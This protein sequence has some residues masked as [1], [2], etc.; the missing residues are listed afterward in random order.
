MKKLLVPALVLAAIGFASCSDEI[1][2]GFNSDPLAVKFKTTVGGVE[3][4][5]SY[6]YVNPGTYINIFLSDE[7]IY[8]YVAADE[9]V[10][11]PTG[12]DFLRWDETSAEANS[13]YISAYTPTID[14]ATPTTFTLA[15]LANQS[16]ADNL[17]NADYAT[18]EGTISRSSRSTVASFALQRRMAQVKMKI[19]SVD[20]EFTN[21][22]DDKFTF[23]IS[24]YSPSTVVTV[25]SDTVVGDNNPIK[26]T[27]YDGNAIIAPAP[28]DDMAQFIVVNVKKNGEQYGQPL[29][30][31]GRPELEAGCGYTFNL[32][33]HKELVSISSVQLTDWVDVAAIVG[34]E[35][36]RVY[37]FSGFVLNLQDYS[38]VSEARTA[39]FAY[40]NS[41]GSTRDVLVVGRLNSWDLRHILAT[42]SGYW[43]SF[44]EGYEYGSDE[45]CDPELRSYWMDHGMHSIDFSGV[46]DMP[47]TCYDGILFI[48]RHQ[49]TLQYVRAQLTKLDTPMFGYMPALVEIDLPMI[50]SIPVECFDECTSLE[51][52]RMPRV[53]SIG[54]YAF[55]TCDRLRTLYI[56][57]ANTFGY[58]F[59][60]CETSDVDVT[61]NAE[62]KVNV[63]DGHWW[64]APGVDCE[65]YFKTITYEY[66]LDLDNYSTEAD[67]NAA[68][69]NY[70][71]DNTDELRIRII[72]SLNGKSLVNILKGC[73]LSY[74]NLD[75]VSDLYEMPQSSF[76]KTDVGCTEIC[77]TQIIRLARQAFQLS[78]VQTFDLPA[79]SYVGESAFAANTALSSLTLPKAV[80]FADNGFGGCSALTDISLP[81]ARALGNQLFS[82]CTSLTDVSIPLA[83]T[84]GQD[85]FAGTTTE[86]INITL[87]SAQQANVSG[88]TWCVPGTS[89]TYTFKSISFAK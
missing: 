16:R 4:R 73:S 21:T 19:T 24:V 64:N 80:N 10:L 38:D 34:G 60:D 27:P 82:D 29:V 77:A 58:C 44:I 33:V 51:T 2:Y 5:S 42:G 23:D 78:S 31:A 14:A 3:S 72:G 88:N 39:L 9:G 32:T 79:V 17:L 22:A 89:N 65:Y 75:E 48:G 57:Q 30:A 55:Q 45:P 69:L 85:I 6:E 46:V 37:D 47:T 86:N 87:N 54:M 83:R 41:E 76:V 13:L 66:I 40:L 62:Q 70:C 18:F 35:A 63:R 59:Y 12:S 36:D 74:V 28:A 20:D 50:E 15:D 71:K 7:D 56:P 67:A 81:R 61:I 8:T 1:Y 49:Y 84:F 43:G 25:T 53:K 52:I 11:K 26:I 68:I